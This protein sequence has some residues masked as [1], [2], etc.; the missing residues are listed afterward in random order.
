MTSMRRWLQ[1][2]FPLAL[3]ACSTTVEQLQIKLTNPD[4]TCKDDIL[5]QIDGVR[6][7]LRTDG[8]KQKSCLPIKDIE[9]KSIAGMQGELE[10]TTRFEDLAQGDH[11]LKV[12]GYDD[13]CPDTSELLACGYVELH[14]PA[15]AAS[16]SLPMTCYDGLLPPP[17]F[18]DCRNK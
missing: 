1:L 2:L 18:A 17:A 3:I 15:E 13:G 10:R 8:T 4:N 9:I 11:G 5:D 16:V 6:V 14:I 12:T 7:E